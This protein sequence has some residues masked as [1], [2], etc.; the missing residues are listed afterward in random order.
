VSVAHPPTSMEAPDAPLASE[1]TDAYC[2]GWHVTEAE[3]R[4]CA[5]GELPARWVAY[6]IE[7]LP[8][9]DAPAGMVLARRRTRRSSR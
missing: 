3:L 2:A 1:P 4:A 7:L 6:A 5:Q 9:F 8:W